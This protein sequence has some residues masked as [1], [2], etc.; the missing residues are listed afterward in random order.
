MNVVPAV[1]EPAFP[2]SNTL[3]GFVAGLDG[4]VTIAPYFQVQPANIPSGTPFAFTVTEFSGTDVVNT[5]YTGTVAFSS[6]DTA[7][8]PGNG[9]PNNST[10]HNGVG[11]FSATL[12]TAGAQYLSASDTLRPPSTGLHRSS[13]SRWFLTTWSSTRRRT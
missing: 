5:G 13:F 10:L 8:S 7:V 2:V 3:S 4:I 11:T 6:S 9:L 1:T 12:V